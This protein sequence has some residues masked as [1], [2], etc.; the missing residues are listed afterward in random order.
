MHLGCGCRSVL[1]RHIL[2]RELER[3]RLSPFR[4]LWLHDR[5]RLSEQLSFLHGRRLHVLGGDS[6]R[7]RMRL[8]QVSRRNL[9]HHRIRDLR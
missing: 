4:E 5:E 1:F 2:L 6:G 9:R 8:L 7:G 3:N